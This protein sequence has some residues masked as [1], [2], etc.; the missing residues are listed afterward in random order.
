MR[1]ASDDYGKRISLALAAVQRMHADV[2]KLLVDAEATIGKGKTSA[3]GSYAT[4]DLTYNFR[5]DYWMAEGVYRVWAAK[6]PADQT[7]VDAL[8]VRFFD[9]ESRIEEPYLILG[10]I[11]YELE[12]GETALRYLTDRS[13]KGH[14]RPW[15]LW[16][17]Y[18][19][20]SGDR[21]P[22]GEVLTGGPRTDLPVGWFKVIGVPLY[23]IT[24]MDDVTGLMDR[25]RA[26]Q[27][28]A[29]N[30]GGQP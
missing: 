6:P 24:K 4:K 22:P 9:Q 13:I 25:V 3:Y 12:A 30:T 11:K 8:T 17:A 5:A 26:A 28:I 18:V 16:H 10:Q 23:A 27:V 2:S 21:P 20:W 7:V 15:H 19:A 14:K 29:E 1:D